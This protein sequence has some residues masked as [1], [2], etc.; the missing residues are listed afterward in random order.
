MSGGKTLLANLANQGSVI[1]SIMMDSFTRQL[2]GESNHF[3][4]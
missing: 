3:A 1:D 2:S 4:R